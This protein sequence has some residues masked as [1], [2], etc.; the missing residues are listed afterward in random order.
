M[1][2]FPDDLDHF[3]MTTGLLLLIPD[4]TIFMPPDVPSIEEQL[5]EWRQ[6][7]EYHGK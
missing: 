1:K 5:P 6:T 2:L 7:Y 4:P 3:D